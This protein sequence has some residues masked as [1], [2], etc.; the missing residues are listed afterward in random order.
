MKQILISGCWECPFLEVWATFWRCSKCGKV[1]G[2]S[3]GEL[4]K[5]I[6]YWCPLEDQK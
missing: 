6:P 1:T 2:G 3:V 4:Q 5:E